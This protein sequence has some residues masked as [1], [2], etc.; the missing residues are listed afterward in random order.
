MSSRSIKIIM[1]L[2]S[3]VHRVHMENKTNSERETKTLKRSTGL[4]NSNLPKQMAHGNK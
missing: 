4:R 1:F 3:K 2:G